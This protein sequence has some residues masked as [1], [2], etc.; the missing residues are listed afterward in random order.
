MSKIAASRRLPRSGRHFANGACQAGLPLAKH[1]SLLMRYY[2]ECTIK[3]GSLLLQFM[4]PSLLR[5]PYGRR[6]GILR[7][8]GRNL[9]CAG[10]IALLGGA[11]HF[12]YQRFRHG[13]FLRLQPSLHLLS[14]PRD[15]SRKSRPGHQ[16]RKTLSNLFGASGKRCQ[17]YQPSHADALHSANLACSHRSK[18]AGSYPAYC[19]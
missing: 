8:N 11:L 6:H 1:T 4:S 18:K 3:R 12:R 17:Q 13:L 7:S 14:E 15:R 10:C 5:G 19:L 16:L 9:C 2:H